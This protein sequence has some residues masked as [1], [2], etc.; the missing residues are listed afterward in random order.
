M[1]TYAFISSAN[2]SYVQL[3]SILSSLL[4]IANTSTMMT[5]DKDVDPDCRVNNP[6]FYGA[7]PAVGRGMVFFS[8]FT[9]SSCH[10]LMKVL[11]TALLASVGGVY[12]GAY[13]GG[14]MLFYF[15]FKAARGDF[16]Y[17]L[18]VPGVLSAAMSATSRLMIKLMVDFTCLLVARSPFEEGGLYFSISILISHASCFVAAYLYINDRASS[19]SSQEGPK[20][21]GAVELWAFLGGVEGLF[22][23]SFTFYL[24]KIKRKYVKTFFSTMTGKQF[25]VYTFRN[26]ISDS[27]KVRI[28]TRHPSYYASTRDEVKTWVGENWERWSE[29]KP[30]WFTARVI[31]TIPDDMI[32]T[33]TL[34]KLK[35]RG[36][37]RSSA[38]ELLLGAPVNT[39]VRTDGEA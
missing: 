14:D 33:A 29:E 11:S 38:S 17:W 25:C 1:Q 26:A 35:R 24:L 18:N 3:I 20:K 28:F 5:F 12:V 7:I 8:M 13:L 30:A 15:L 21:F 34:D 23:L 22:I 9:F 19:A 27:A 6:S 16:R 31:S 2:S 4:A 10:V 39:S 36:R 37:R 32:P